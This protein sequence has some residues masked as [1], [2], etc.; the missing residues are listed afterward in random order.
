MR[1]YFY[2]AARYS[3]SFD[4]VTLKLLRFLSCLAA[5]SLAFPVLAR[6]QSLP[7]EAEAVKKY[8]LNSDYPEVFSE[9]KYRV[10]VENLIVADLDGDGIPEVI[11]HM[12]PH[13]R[14]SPTIII[15]K[16]SKDLQV[17]RVMEG[18]APGPLQP[19]SDKYL[20][21]HSLGEGVDFQVSTKSGDSADTGL[22]QGL[23]KSQKGGLVLYKQFS[24]LD[25]R[26]GL[27]SYIDMRDAD[28]PPNTKTCAEF[29]FADVEQVEVTPRY[30]SDGRN[31]IA[32]RIGKQIYAIR[33]E[34]FLPNGLLE[35]SVTVH[36]L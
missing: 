8:L 29:E 5:V 13:F 14:Q 25:G 17:Q 30:S 21:S 28:L 31:V 7:P 9:T 22:V 10:K 23:V 34:H 32:A 36:A 26:R 16:V 20:D 35:K 1:D 33:I 12:K 4:E 18:L 15:F 3:S 2:W 11:V 24:H 27:P 6:A 19:R